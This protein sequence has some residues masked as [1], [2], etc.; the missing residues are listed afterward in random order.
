MTPEINPYECPIARVAAPSTIVECDVGSSE[1][2]LKLARIFGV[3]GLLCPGTWMAV[4]VTT[5]SLTLV[6][7]SIAESNIPSLVYGMS[8][9]A[10]SVAQL[11]TIAFLLT[12][13]CGSR[14]TALRLCA[15]SMITLHSSLLGMILLDSRD[16]TAD[17]GMGELAEFMFVFALVSNLILF[18]LLRL[19]TAIFACRS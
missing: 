3:L 4:L 6:V 18:G 16:T 2:L 13:S 5:V 15:T 19:S 14:P 17:C 1:R 9:F 10:I 7:Q 12:G 11:W 8:L